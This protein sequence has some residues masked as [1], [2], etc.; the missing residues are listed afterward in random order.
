MALTHSLSMSFWIH[1]NI[2]ILQIHVPMSNHQINGVAN[3]PIDWMAA[4]VHTWGGGRGEGQV[5]RLL[6][7]VDIRRTEIQIP[8]MFK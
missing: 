2:K 5:H 1:A 8:A 3:V 7:R 4:P 6:D